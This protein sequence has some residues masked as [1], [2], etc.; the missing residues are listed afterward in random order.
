MQLLESTTKKAAALVR[1]ILSFARGVE[2]KRMPVPIRYILN[3]VRQIIRQTFPKSIDLE[4]TVEPDVESV[5][6]DATQL[7]QVFMNLCVNARDAMPY[8][9]LLRITA[10]NT[11]VDTNFAQ[12]Q[13]DAKPG[14]YILVT[15]VDNGTGIPSEIQDRIFEPFFTTK[16]IEEGTGLPHLNVQKV[17]VKP[18]SSQELLNILHDLV[19]K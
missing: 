2:S 16:P 1:Q 8:G 6:A 13:Q 3:D 15:L 11:I 12:M 7:H 10:T 18:F 4:V 19:S 5:F 9:G 14:R 17:L